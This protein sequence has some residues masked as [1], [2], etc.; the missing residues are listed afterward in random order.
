MSINFKFLPLKDLFYSVFP[1]VGTYGGYLEGVAPSIFPNPWISLG[2]GL[3]VSVI[4]ALI[5]YLEN[6]RAYKKSLAEILAT[7]Y[8]MNFTGRLGK[9]LQSK[10][11]INFLFPDGNTLTFTSDQIHIE[12]GLPKDLTS[13]KQYADNAIKE[14]KVVY[15]REATQSEPFWV[16]AKVDGNNLTIFEFPRTLFALPSYLK[17][18]FKDPKSAQKHSRKIFTYFRE[19]I[20]RLQI[21][22][23]QEIPLANMAFKKL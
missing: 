14:S 5:F 22:A 11:P 8:F 17:E 3:L 9:L 7:G 4:L 16:R 6:V 12:I 2:I 13:L 10:A 15:I 1:T 18:D 23:S 19:Y 21:S 20:E